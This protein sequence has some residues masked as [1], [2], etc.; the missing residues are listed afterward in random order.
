MTTDNEGDFRSDGTVLCHNYDD[1]Y[2]N[3]VYK[4]DVYILV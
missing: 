2:M 4:Y 3:D 1:V